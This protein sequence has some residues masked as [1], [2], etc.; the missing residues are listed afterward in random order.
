MS[1]IRKKND[2]S[3]GR[4]I[5]TKGGSRPRKISFG[6]AKPL[7]DALPGNPNHSGNLIGVQEGLTADLPQSSPASRG[8]SFMSPA[9]FA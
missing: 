7:K 8:K 9:S 4:S 1:G 2:V 6:C 3:I 5:E